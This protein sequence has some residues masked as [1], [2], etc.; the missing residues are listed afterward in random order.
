M[1]WR[2]MMMFRKL[3]TTGLNK[4][5]R[6]I[7]AILIVLLLLSGLPAMALSA[8]SFSDLKKGSWYYSEVDAAIENGIFEGGTDGKFYPEST[9]NRA[10]FVVALARLCK[11]DVSKE[12]S[13]P[14]KDVPK[15]SYYYGAVSWAYRVGVANGVSETEFNPEA[16][17]TREQMCKMLGA[18]LEKVLSIRLSA[19]GAP[20]FGDAAK[21]SSFAKDW[22]AKCAAAEIFKGDAVGNFNPQRTA[23]RA[24]AAVVLYRCFAKYVKVPDADAYNITVSGFSLKFDAEDDYYLAYPSDFTKCKITGYTGFK[25]IKVSVEQY[26]TYF[27]YSSTAYKLGDNLKLGHG[28]AKLT[29][30][31]TLKDGTVRDYMIALTDPEGNDNS[32]ASVRVNTEVNLRQGPSSSTTSLKKLKNGVKVYYLETVNEEWCK[33]QLMKSATIGYIHRDYLQWNW[34]ETQMHGEYANAIAALKKKHPN[35]SF[36]FVDVEKDYNA[37]M[38]EIAQERAEVRA[39]ELGYSESN[40]KYAEKVEELMEE[41]LPQVATYMDPRYYL[42][43]DRIFAFLDIDTYDTSLWIDAGIKAIW[44]NT[45]ALQQNPNIISKADAVK[46]IKNASASLQMNPYYIACRAALESGYGK[47]QFARGAVKGYEGY[48]NFFGIKCY[49]S[50]PSIGAQYAK[51]RNW[52]TEERSIIEGA[53]WMK[54]VYLDRGSVTPYFF[55]YASFKQRFDPGAYIYMSDLTAP[56]SEATMLRRAYSDADAKAHFIVPVYQG[57]T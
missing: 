32:Y 45:Y 56:S 6:G 28:R 16:K 31:A 38:E 11:V 4:F 55:R 36:T 42:T 43:E 52:N 57:M 25:S 17:I 27:P 22:V 29:I 47:S 19:D 18:A 7:A 46:Y 33:V 39:G 35:W 49:D 13:S 5:R 30:T 8:S 40:P 3:H 37:Y 20:K 44:N 14:F 53:N 15:N 51:E 26:A 54:D 50:N 21:I 12:S 23:T 48:Y 41:Y 34:E 1:L 2:T 10:Q 9:I 24:E